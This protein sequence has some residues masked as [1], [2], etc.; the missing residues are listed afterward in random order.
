MIGNAPSIGI[1]A[2]VHNC[3][4]P[5]GPI[6]LVSSLSAYFSNNFRARWA[7]YGSGLF[8]FLGLAGGLCF[9]ALGVSVLYPLLD[10]VCSSGGNSYKG[11]VFKF[12]NVKVK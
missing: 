8:V 7:E 9:S 11:L 12:E 5:S 2:S 6:T 1:L 3:T 4:N 10:A